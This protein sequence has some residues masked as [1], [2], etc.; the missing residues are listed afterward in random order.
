MS[1]IYDVVDKFFDNALL[2]S[3]FS[4]NEF[5]KTIPH[6]MRF[7]E[8]DSVDEDTLYW[9]TQD[10][11]GL[12]DLKIFANA[13]TKTP[14]SKAYVTIRDF[15]SYDFQ[16]DLDRGVLAI[17]NTNGDIV[18]DGYLNK[19]K[20]REWVDEEG[21]LNEADVSIDTEI[22]NTNQNNPKSEVEKKLESLIQI[23][24]N[25]YKLNDVQLSTTDQ[26]NIN[27][28]VD[29]KP[30]LTLDASN[31]SE[32]DLEDLRDKGYFNEDTSD[33]LEEP[34]EDNIDNIQEES[35]NLTE[36]VVPAS[37]LDFGHQQLAKVQS[38]IE[39]IAGL[40]AEDTSNE[41]YTDLLNAYDKV[42]KVLSDYIAD[43]PAGTVIGQDN[44]SL[45]ISEPVEEIEEEI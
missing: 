39:L 9:V 14:Y 33:D 3:Y 22:S 31:F 34:V 17:V 20:E 1:K 16:E 15:S 38:D 44:N 6:R 41:L 26:G 27:V 4:G 19:A 29:N 2:E 23:M 25:D 13:L 36:D 37:Q 24:S 5:E 43:S 30:V 42:M 40:K 35:E 8:Y 7:K 10:A 18:A 11:F 32:N 45:D 12:S 28:E 21:N